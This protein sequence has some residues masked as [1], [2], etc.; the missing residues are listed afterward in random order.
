MN[1]SLHSQAHLQVA[2]AATLPKPAKELA[3]PNAQAEKYA[4]KMKDRMTKDKNGQ[5]VTRAKSNRA[6][7]G[8]LKSFATNNLYRK[9]A[10]LCFEMPTRS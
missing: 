3:Y 1:P 6:Y 8:N 10:V 7:S 4:A 9:L 5:L 2:Q